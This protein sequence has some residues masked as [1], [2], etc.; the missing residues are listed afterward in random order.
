MLSFPGIPVSVFP[1]KVTIFSS[2][3]PEKKAFLQ[4]FREIPTKFPCF[5]GNF[6]CLLPRFPISREKF[7]AGK[8]T[9]LIGTTSAVLWLTFSLTFS[10]PRK[11]MVYAS[12]TCQPT[13]IPNFFL[14][15]HLHLNT[16]SKKIL[17]TV[18]H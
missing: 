11:I 2:R 15:L 1:G 18:S 13:Q 6:M 12:S 16:A 8:L 5:P 14:L 7:L 4:Y 3:F 10:T 17:F 9:A